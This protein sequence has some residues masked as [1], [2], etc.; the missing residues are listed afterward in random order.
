MISLFDA[1][2][3]YTLSYSAHYFCKFLISNKCLVTDFTETETFI[4]FSIMQLVMTMNLR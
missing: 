1:S 4:D 3:V 2:D